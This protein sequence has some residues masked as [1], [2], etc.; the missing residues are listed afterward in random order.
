MS[1]HYNDHQWHWAWSLLFWSP[2]L[3]QTKKC[4]VYASQCIN[5]HACM[6]EVQYKVRCHGKY[7]RYRSICLTQLFYLSSSNFSSIFHFEHCL[8]ISQNRYYQILSLIFTI[9][10]IIT[11]VVSLILHSCSFKKQRLTKLHVFSPMR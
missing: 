3:G 4:N 6:L 5:M 8:P 10:V 1:V 11:I 9:K 7:Q 2:T